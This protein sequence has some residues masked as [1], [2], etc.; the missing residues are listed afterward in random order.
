MLVTSAGTYYVNC[1][2]S[3][4]SV[5]QSPPITIYADTIPVAVN[6]PDTTLVCPGD[7]AYLQAPLFYSSYMWSTGSTA[8]SILADST[9]SYWFYAMDAN[10][11]VASSDTAHIVTNELHPD[12]WA[13]VLS[14]CSGGPLIF[15]NRIYTTPI[16]QSY[17]WGTNTTLLPS[18]L[19]TQ[20]GTQ[21]C[22]L[23]TSPSPR[24]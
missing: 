4:G 18:T 12:I 6:P 14:L 19:A 5:C 9:G 13:D 15:L 17:Q 23:Y 22:L 2:S 3:N 16:Y 1:T 24:D 20:S 10:G 11:C 8:Q 7:T 21:A